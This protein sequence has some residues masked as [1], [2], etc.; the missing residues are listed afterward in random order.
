MKDG[1]DEMSGGNQGSSGNQGL[2]IDK[3][4]DVV[5]MIVK[6]YGITKDGARQVV[7]FLMQKLDMPTTLGDE[8]MNRLK[9]VTTERQILRTLEEFYNEKMWAG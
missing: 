6:E 1:R 4:T 7:K 3:I 9:S 2:P 5:S 8:L